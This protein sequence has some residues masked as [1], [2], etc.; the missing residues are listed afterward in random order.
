M[1]HMWLIICGALVMFMHAG[2]AMLEAGCCRAGF[3]QSVSQ[4]ASVYW[5]SSTRCVQMV[6]TVYACT[7]Q[8]FM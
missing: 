3:V 2:F 4:R 8:D 7:I 1:T 5:G 6:F